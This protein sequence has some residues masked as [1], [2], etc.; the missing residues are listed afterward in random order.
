MLLQN[1]KN[2]KL[3]LIWLILIY[4]KRY[5]VQAFYPKKLEAIENSICEMKI[6]SF[7]F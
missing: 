2:L 7:V 1:L 5:L 4:Q 6:E 3:F